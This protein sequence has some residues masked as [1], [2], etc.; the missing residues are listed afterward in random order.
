MAQ[1][2]GAC[3]NSQDEQLLSKLSADIDACVESTNS[4]AT[5]GACLEKDGFTDGCTQCVETMVGCIMTD[6]PSCQSSDSATCKQCYT[7]KCTPAFDT[8]SGLPPQEL[9]TPQAGKCNSN[10]LSL[11]SGLAKDIPACMQE[12]QTA[13]GIAACIEKDGFSAPCAGCVG[14]YGACVIDN[15]M[16]DC[17]DP[18]S[19]TCKT[20]YNTKCMPAFL[21]CTG[22][23][24]PSVLELSPAPL[25]N[26]FV[27]NDDRLVIRMP[28]TE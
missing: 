10:D 15:C 22:F 3:M 11:A 18:T 14:T 19:A 23:P 27:A 8:C 6:C 26:N 21:S 24:E 2:S 25:H 4:E 20:C 28:R 12:S 17:A 16:S 13:S 7:A 9:A 1:A 5:F